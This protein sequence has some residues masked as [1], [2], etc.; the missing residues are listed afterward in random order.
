MN[1][2]EKLSVAIC[3]GSKIYIDWTIR[4]L[5]IHSWNNHLTLNIILTV[6][7]HSCSLRIFLSERTTVTLATV[8]TQ[9]Y[10]VIQIH[11]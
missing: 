1:G 9:N 7:T 10:L 5:S 8:K 4:S 6:R 11:N 2:E 3:D